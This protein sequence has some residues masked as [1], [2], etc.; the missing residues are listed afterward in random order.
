MS[1]Q[2]GRYVDDDYHSPPKC[3]RSTHHVLE[4]D[5][6][7]SDNKDNQSSMGDGFHDPRD[8]LKKFGRY[9]TDE[10]DPNEEDE[11]EYEAHGNE[12]SIWSPVPSGLCEEKLI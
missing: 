11:D 8:F 7:E 9:E 2:K 1:N 6:Y 10:E 3:R 5:K 4:S 12:S